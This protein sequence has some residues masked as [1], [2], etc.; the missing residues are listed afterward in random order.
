VVEHFLNHKTLNKKWKYFILATWHT[1]KGMKLICNISYRMSRNYVHI[2][3]PVKICRDNKNVK[4]KN[5]QVYNYIW[6]EEFESL[7]AKM[8]WLK[9][10]MIWNETQKSHTIYFF[11][12]GKE[13]WNP[14]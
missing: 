2:K 14:I 5:M 6:I 3:Y 10:Y 1:E 8:E 9:M 12:Y 4:S 7:E 13:W 11:Q